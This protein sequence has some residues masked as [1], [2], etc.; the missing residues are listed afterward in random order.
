MKK[1]IIIGAG[2]AGTVIAE[3]LASRGYLVNIYEKRDHIGGNM[4]DYYDESGILIHKY[5][6]HLFHTNNTRVWEYIQPFTTWYEYAPEATTYIDGK[7]IPFVFNLNSIRALYPDMYKIITEKLTIKYGMDNSV[8]ILELI[9]SEDPDLRQMANELYKKDFLPYT[10]KQW[11][12]SPIEINE[13]VTA[14]VPFRISYSNVAYPDQ[15]QVMPSGGY[16]RL[17]K[18]MLANPNISIQ[19]NTNIVDFIKVHD[20]AITWEG[21]PINDSIVIYTGCIDELFDFCFG[22]LPYR[23][24]EFEN[25]TESKYPS[26]PSWV[27]CFPGLEFPYTRICEYRHIMESQPNINQTTLV[28]EYSLEYS[29]KA[30]KGNIPY[31]AVLTETN[32]NIYTRYARL[33]NTIPNLYLVGRLAE[34][35]YYDMDQVIAR[36]LDMADEIMSKVIDPHL[37][38]I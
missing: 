25:K 1:V 24:L 32:L 10:Q 20:N 13:S 36:A 9:N 37:L 33:A 11:G 3:R 34:Y 26:Q 29:S 7:Y 18:N 30:E 2:F 5:G 8:H 16:A 12:L 22:S 38:R 17:F 28:Y 21:K 6:P 15:I 31:Y 19:L 14:R 4:F 27:A 23:S 35:K